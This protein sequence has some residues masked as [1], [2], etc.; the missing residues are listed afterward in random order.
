MYFIS[1][2]SADV[3][4]IK[5]VPYESYGKIEGFES[6]YPESFMPQQKV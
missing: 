6:P 2:G 5:E 3:F 1:N 4:L